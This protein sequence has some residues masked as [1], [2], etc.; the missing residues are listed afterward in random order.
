[1]PVGAGNTIDGGAA[2]TTLVNYEYKAILTQSLTYGMA[3]FGVVLIAY[4]VVKD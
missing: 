4:G 2:Q 3:L 1:M